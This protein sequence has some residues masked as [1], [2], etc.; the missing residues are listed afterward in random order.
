MIRRTPIS[1]RDLSTGRLTRVESIR[2]RGRT[3]RAEVRFEAEGMGD[4]GAVTIR[5]SGDETTTA[6]EWDAIRWLKSCAAHLAAR[7]EVRR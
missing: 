1:G 4:D 2:R 6:T 3:W 7:V 5:I